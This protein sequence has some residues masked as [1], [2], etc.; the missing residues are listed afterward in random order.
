MKKLAPAW[1]FQTGDY[2]RGCNRRPIVIDGVLYLSTTHS[3]VFAL[4]AAT[5]KKIW[6]YKYPVPRG[7]GGNIQN[8]GVAVGAGKVFV[9]TYD[10][11]VV[12]ID[13]KTGRRSLESGDERF[14]A[15]RLQHYRGSVVRE[16]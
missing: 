8:R 6:Q 2:D 4:D 5:G 14:A 12:A 3:Q 15:M 1:V 7:A 10:D 11:Y 13:Q 9:G 16:R